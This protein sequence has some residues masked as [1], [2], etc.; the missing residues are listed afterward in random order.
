MRGAPAL[1]RFCYKTF[2]RFS[3]RQGF[4]SARQSIQIDSMS[5]DLRNTLWNILQIYVW[6]DGNKSAVYVGSQPQQIRTL[7]HKLWF[8]YFKQPLDTM[9]RLW[10][11]VIRVLRKDFFECEWYEVYDFVEFVTN[12]YPPKRDQLVRACNQML[13]REA[14][15]YRFLGGVLSPITDKAEIDEIDRALEGPA[16]PVHTHL[17]RALELLSDRAN[18]DYRNS[19]KESISA[20]ES[21]VVATVGEKGT[22]GQ[23]IKKME[24]DVGLHPALRTAFSS[25]YG[26]TSDQ[27]GIRHAI[28]ELQH[29]GFEDAKFFLVVCS[30]FVNFVRGRLTVL[31]QTAQ[32]SVSK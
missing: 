30:A 23:L 9:D 2:M 10:V 24:E 12:S 16:D 14:S 1:C 31:K 5:P 7:C 26:Y 15:G 13:E 3:E 18:P 6:A 28:L 22:L 21:L 32:P 17:R 8:D 11:N 20:V 19:I 29:I 25:L 27:D 4:K